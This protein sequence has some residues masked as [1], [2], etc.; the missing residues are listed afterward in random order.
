MTKKL[1]PLIYTHDATGLTGSSAYLWALFLAREA[2]RKKDFV[3]YDKW[4]SV[5]DWLKPE[6]HGSLATS[7][8][9][10]VD[11]MNAIQE[12]LDDENSNADS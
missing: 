3:A 5:I 8:F 2:D 7:S 6:T 1:P 12:Y 9:Y 11:L 10:S 4:R